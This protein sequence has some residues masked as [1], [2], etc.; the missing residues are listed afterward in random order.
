MIP[1]IVTNVQQTLKKKTDVL[2][3]CLDNRKT[4][5]QT[6]VSTPF[7]PCTKMIPTAFDTL[8]GGLARMPRLMLY[9]LWICR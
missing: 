4:N 9:K 2:Y 7:I 8:S 6:N 3:L 5:K 1:K